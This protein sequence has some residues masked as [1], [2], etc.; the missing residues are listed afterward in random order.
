MEILQNVSLKPFNTFGVDVKAAFFVHIKTI[1]ELQ[2]LSKE[3]LFKNSSKL[4]L[5][6]GSNIL[7]TK[8][9]EGLVLK[10]DL[11]GI[12]LL[13]DDAKYYYVSVKGGENWHQF[14]LRSIKENWQGLEN[15]S[16]IP[17]TVGAAP[18]QNIGA[19]GVEVADCIE[20]V[21]AMEIASGALHTFDATACKFGYRNSVFKQEL[22]GQFLIYEVIFKLNKIPNH[23]ITY[24]PLEA[25]LQNFSSDELT[26]KMISDAVIAI[27]QSKLPDP[28][29]IGNCGSFF[30]NP[31][32]PRGL[33]NKLF[34]LYPNMPIYP[35]G[36]KEVKIPAGW[37]I[38]KC[39]LKGIK[40]G[41]VG[42]YEKQALVLVNHGRAT[43]SE[44]FLFANKIINS[45]KETFGISLEPEVNIF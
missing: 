30:K 16:L 11:Q 40:E 24:K 15:L 33:S 12:E 20:S 44:A 28:E 13:G 7:F 18:I 19:Y 17:G 6:G 34:E 10:T 4:I 31:V 22:K 43:G 37:L 27:R 42:T 5:G 38:E 9:F 14:V 21:K 35:V 1:E 36:E 41:N 8:D 2:A 23:N 25:A 45:V 32:V 29:T 26:A 3:A 39:G